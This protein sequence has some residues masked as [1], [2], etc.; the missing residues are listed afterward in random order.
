MVAESRSAQR[1][2][3][4]PA[5]WMEADRPRALNGQRSSSSGRAGARPGLDGESAGWSHLSRDVE[6]FVSPSPTAQAHT[7]TSRERTS[8]TFVPAMLSR[9]LLQLA[10]PQHARRLCSRQTA[11]VLHDTI[12]SRFA[13]HQ[14]PKQHLLRK[15]ARAVESKEDSE[16]LLAAHRR[17]VLAQA[18]M[19]GDN[20]QLLLEA[21]CRARNWGTLVNVLSDSQRHQLFFEEAGSVQM[22]EQ[23]ME[24]LRE[25]GEWHQL[26]RLHARLP[27]MGVHEEGLEAK[28]EEW[29]REAPASE[30][31]ADEAVDEAAAADPGDSR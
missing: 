19:R 11:P 29:L 30:G 13:E 25:D 31:P 17:F 1:G 9:P 3:L 5:E 22:I 21:F 8:R 7:A 20:A 27:A 26:R 28:V 14:P 4:E 2:R 12:M 15:L 6:R 18:E 24:G 16:L 23:V 10:R